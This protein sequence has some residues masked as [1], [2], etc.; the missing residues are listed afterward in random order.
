ME[1]EGTGTI[2]ISL[3]LDS[4]GF[5]RRACENCNREFKWL[6]NPDGEQAEALYHCPYCGQPGDEWATQEQQEY[7]QAMA[8][9]SPKV[10]HAVGELHDAAMSLN[11][12]SSFLGLHVTFEGFSPDEPEPLQEPDDMQA[13]TPTCHP[14]EPIKI[15]EDWTGSTHC[16]IC[17]QVMH[18][19]HDLGNLHV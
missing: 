3:P 6:H 11:Q 13:I 12:A 7:M 9:S 17:G 1:H 19:Q 18:A 2:T 16:L 10:Q 4:D 15:L 8:L 5:L 14:A